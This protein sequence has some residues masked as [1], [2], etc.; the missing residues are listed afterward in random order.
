M[1][2]PYRAYWIMGCLCLGLTPA[3]NADWPTYRQDAGRTGATAHELRLP[4]EFHWVQ[5]APKPPEKAWAGPDNRTFEGLHLRDRM[6]FDDAF[7]GAIVAGRVY[8]GSSV[9]HQVRCLDLA[10]GKQLWTYFTGAAVR[11]APTV[12]EGRVYC[13]SDDGY[14]YCLDADSGKLLWRLQAGPEEAWFL[15]RGEMISRW[16]IRTGV[17]VYDG[18]AY[19]G[20]GIFPHEDIFLYAVDARTGKVIWKRDDLSEAD[21]TRNPL[22]PQG[23]LLVND[24]YLFVPSGRS[25]PVCF[26][27]HTGKMIHQRTHSW[28]KE[29]VMGG[30]RAL[31][32]DGQIYA[33]GD[34]QLVA[35]D[36]KTGDVGFG[37]FECKQMVT[38]GDDWAYIIDGQRLARLDRHAYAIASRERQKLREGIFNVNRQLRS[39]PKNAANLKAQLANLAEQLKQLE[40]QGV[41]WSVPVTAEAGLLAAGNW[42]FVGGPDSVTAYEAGTGKQVWQAKVE[43]NARGLAA[44]DHY[45]LVSTSTGKVYA[46]ADAQAK[47]LPVVPEAPTAKQLFPDDPLAA[48]YADA[49]QEILEQ[50]GVKEGYCLVLGAERGQLAFELAQRSALK[51]YGIE[52]DAAKVQAA[53]QALTGAGYYGHR[54]VIHQADLADIPYSNF[55]ANLVVSDQYARAGTLPGEPRD[56][57]RHVKP[58]GGTVYLG[59]PARAAGQVDAKAARVWLDALALGETGNIQKTATGLRYVRGPLH[60]AAN[61]THQYGEPGNTACVMD[62]RVKGGLGVLWYGDPGPGKMVNRHDGAVGPL[63]VNGRLI[64]Q[65]QFSVLAYDAY[66]GQFLWEYKNPNTF[67]TGVFQNYNPGNLVATEESI[68]VMEGSKVVQLDAATGKFQTTHELPADKQ[69]DYEWNYIGYRDGILY[70][71]ATVRKELASALQRRGRKFEDATAALFAIDVK[72]GQHLWCHDGDNIAAQTIALGPHRVYFI[73]STLSSEERAALLRSERDQVKHLTGEEA[74]QAEERLKRLDV[75]R[76]IALEARTGKQLWAEAVDVTDCSDI[77]IGGGKL[78]LMVSEGV[79]VLCGANANGHYWKQFVEGEFKQRRLVALSAKDG[80]KLWAKDANYRHRPI[81]VGDRIIAEPWAFELRTGA[82]ITRPHPLTGAEVPW[83]MYRPGHHCGMLVA[84]PNMLMFRSGFTGF[85]DLYE[86]SGTQHFAG[87]RLGCWIN[88]IPANGLVTIPEASAGCVCQF[89]IAST[90]VLEPRPTTRR[91]WTIYSSVG[92]NTPVQHLALNLG[93]PGDRK[94]ERGTVWLAYP[95]PNPLRDSTLDLR[96]DLKPQFVKGGEFTH[97]SSAAHEVK[98]TDAPAWVYTSWAKGLTQCSVPLLGEKDPPATYSVRL[99]FADLAENRQA[100]Q[101]LFDVKVN[102]QVVR[103]NLDITAARSP[104]QD[105]VV[106]QLDA[107]RVTRDLDIELIPRQPNPTEEQLPILNAIEVRRGGERE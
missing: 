7:H 78:T 15:G 1:N 93:A 102:G 105:T 71:T 89:S 43:G 21:A 45:L 25:L 69:R 103:A 30:T 10:R 31:L 34:H 92:S 49:A 33:A 40:N 41:V 107:V 86:D 54:V 26:D 79:L 13:G 81:I 23:Y 48:M 68:L 85:Y 14:V 39:A 9:D 82:T 19:F 60:G 63:S 35:L 83:S 8:F 24:Q 77:G 52:P 17:A 84:A 100:G 73:D 96:L 99:H 18:V 76:A 95:R 58:L 97:V 59:R 16:P 51:V 12:W 61:W 53:R 55:F 38:V 28:R 98:T 88:A 32:A 57:T 42:V 46:F 70:G 37:Y 50:T 2:H 87:H 64:V 11:L 27:R 75:R 65:G 22:S 94:D 20:A 80:R 74:K 66:N 4:L 44:A 56:F 5:S 6:D 104:E 62:H 90:I 3:A 67:R 91:T 101:R 36:E 106:L 29:G 72:T 47:R